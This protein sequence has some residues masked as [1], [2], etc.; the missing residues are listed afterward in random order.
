LKDS[1]T[2]QK[3]KISI[4]ISSYLGEYKGCAVNRIELFNKAIL[5]IL[6]NKYDNF[7]IIV[8]AD[9]CHITI[10]Q[11]SRYADNRIKSIMIPKQKEN[12]GG[13]RNYG[14]QI[15]TGEYICYLDT[16]DYFLD[17]HLEFIVKSFTHTDDWIWFTDVYDGKRRGYV[18]SLNDYSLGTSNI[19]HRRKIKVEWGNGYGHD[20]NIFSNYLKYNRFQMQGKGDSGYV[21]CHIP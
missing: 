9:G 4:I 13:Q 12:F 15:A 11:I 18:N 7:E 20:Q 3:E 8:V 1:S 10:E 5:S 14:L 21:V 17:Y 16:D 6:L 2:M 19:A